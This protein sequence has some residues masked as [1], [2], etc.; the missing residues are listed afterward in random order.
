MKYYRSAIFSSLPEQ[1]ISIPR[2]QT[3]AVALGVDEDGVKAVDTSV[4]VDGLFA[5][6]DLAAGLADILQ[7]LLNSVFA[8]EVQQR[9]MFA[10]LVVAALD[11]GAAG[12]FVFAWKQAKAQVA[13]LHFFETDVEHPFVKGLGPVKILYGDFKPMDEVVERVDHEG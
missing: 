1:Q 9:T 8:V 5:A 12:A 6:Q 13:P 10:G 4:F 7:Q 2:V 3:D 11:N